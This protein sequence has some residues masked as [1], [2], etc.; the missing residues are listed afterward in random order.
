MLAAVSASALGYVAGIIANLID[1]DLF[2]SNNN[3]KSANYYCHYHGHL[4]YFYGLAYT[5]PILR[6]DA[7]G[8]IY[9]CHVTSCH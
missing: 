6:K 5:F 2:K 4:L 8:D 9:C 3:K 7:L 1:F